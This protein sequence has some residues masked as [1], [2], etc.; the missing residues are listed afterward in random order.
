LAELINKR[1]LFPARNYEHLLRLITK[2]CGTLSESELGFINKEKPKEFM[3]NLPPTPRKDFAT[4]FPGADPECLDFLN[5]LLQ[6]DPSKRLTAAQA[7]EHPYFEGFRDPEK[8]RV[9]ERK[10]QWNNL[11]SLVLTN[12]GNP[13]QAR[14]R[15]TK[16]LRDFILNDIVDM[17]PEAE[18]L[19]RN[20]HR[21]ASNGI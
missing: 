5:K 8:E 16:E 2:V 19:Y 10:I 4:I 12:N 1:P 11:E 7:L 21:R 6:I 15:L 20:L 17:N 9:G 13:R 18:S 3:R 14:Q